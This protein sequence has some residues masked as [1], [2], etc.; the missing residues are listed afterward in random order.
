MLCEFNMNRHDLFELPGWSRLWRFFAKIPRLFES[1]PHHNP[2][3]PWWLRWVSP[4]VPGWAKKNKWSKQSEEKH[5]PF[6]EIWDRN[7]TNDASLRIIG[8]S[9]RRVWLCMVPGSPN[10]EFWDLR[11][12]RVWTHVFRLKDGD[13]FGYLCYISV[14][15]MHLLKKQFIIETWVV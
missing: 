13:V 9:Y 3:H 1:H 15:G 7:P 6:P 11:I 12:L 10:H 14:R 5:N 2:H 8:F 4:S